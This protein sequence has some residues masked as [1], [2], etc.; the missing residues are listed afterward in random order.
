MTSH[1]P[2]LQR[3]C[4]CA[5]RE[6]SC[7]ACT[8]HRSATSSHTPA[9]P[10]IVHDVLRSPG[11]PLDAATRA[12]ME[13][14]FGHDFSGV[15]VHSDGR[16]AESARAVSAVAYTV[17]HHIAFDAGEYQPGT[18]SGRR[19]LAH[20]LA[21]VVQQG[22][23]GVPRPSRV[24][25]PDSAHERDAD[26]ISRAVIDERRPSIAERVRPHDD[27]TSLRRLIRTA[28][29][30][31]PG[32][33]PGSS[34]RKAS[35]LLGDALTKIGT[36]E[37]NRVAN[38]ADPDVVSA[39]NALQT[40]FGLDPAL[41]DTWTLRAPNVR[42]PVIK[43]RLEMAKGYIDSVVFTVN[44]PAAGA[45]HTIAPCGAGTCD[46]GTEAFSCHSNAVGID[47]CPLF[48]TRSLDQR[49]R[50]WAHEVF[51]II[52]GVIDDWGSPDAHNAHCYAQF[53]ALLNGFNSPAGYRCH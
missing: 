5:E 15:R 19:V 29:V 37:A 16:A 33:N 38:P 18:E 32:S 53:V 43:R 46:P 48:W 27:A 34:D 51:H 20:E 50:I 8:L 45:S 17:G 4:S 52:I 10:S 49:G 39:G 31:C 26:R 35:S 11:V 47:L 42:L 30:T 14:R 9:V 36:A 23:V 1:G 2:L 21:H 40:A 7:D 24:G 25:A 22:P 41:A 6:K 13:P 12:F 44:C 3:K 28:N